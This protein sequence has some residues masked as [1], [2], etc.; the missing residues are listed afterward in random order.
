MSLAASEALV[1]STHDSTRI[2][3]ESLVVGD[4]V[5][6]LRGDV[7]TVSAVD[8]PEPLSGQQV[9]GPALHVESVGDTPLEMTMPYSDAGVA[10]GTVRLWR[11]ADG[12]S[13]LESTRDADANTVTGEI[14]QAGTV[15]ALGEPADDTSTPADDESTAATPGE[16]A[17]GTATAAGTGTSTPVETTT[18]ASGFG[19]A[20]ALVALVSAFLIIVRHR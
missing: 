15:V 9:A 12:W 4:A 1:T 13:A 14:P 16:T 3:I 20:L 17:T 11:S 19:L 2:V 18:P 6:G 10:E 7:Y 5:F 8:P